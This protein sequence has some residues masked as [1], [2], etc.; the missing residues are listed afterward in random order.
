MTRKQRTGPGGW[1]QPPRL[2]PAWTA[3]RAVWWLRLMQ[4]GRVHRVH[5]ELT[6]LARR[7]TG[8]RS[9]GLLRYGDALR[10][11]W[12]ARTESGPAGP[13]LARAEHPNYLGSPAVVRSL[14]DGYIA[15]LIAR[16]GGVAP[17]VACEAE[18]HRL[19][20]I[21]AGMDAEYAPIGGWNTRGQL[22]DAA[23]RRV[24]LDAGLSQAASLDDVLRET[25]AA[26][27]LAALHILRAAD[28]SEIGTDAALARLS[29][30]A[31]R[32]AALM[33]GTAES[34]PADVTLLSV[35]DGL[36]NVTDGEPARS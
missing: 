3:R 4:A 9:Q 5:G 16:A 33:L 10:Q 28:R 29:D 23:I 17:H 30:L 36:P 25:F 12:R 21:F 14:V 35:S 18:M 6:A 2:V 20:V 32:T 15:L 26:V 7:P 34:L 31:E 1:P 27:G 22:G 19:A 8:P 11:E 24:P 13:A